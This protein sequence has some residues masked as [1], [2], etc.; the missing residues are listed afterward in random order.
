MKLFIM[1]IV[2]E[3]VKSKKVHGKPEIIW[4]IELVLL[5]SF[6]IHIISLSYKKRSKISETDQKTLFLKKKSIDL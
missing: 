5:N 6:Q 1:I 3:L 4:K 2:Q